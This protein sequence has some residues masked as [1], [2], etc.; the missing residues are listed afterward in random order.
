MLRGLPALFHRRHIG[1]RYY[2]VFPR[3]AIKIADKI[4]QPLPVVNRHGHSW[5]GCVQRCRW[6]SPMK[7][8]RLTAVNPYAFTDPL[9]AR[10]P[11]AGVAFARSVNNHWARDVP[12]GYV[13]AFRRPARWNNMDPALAEYYG[14]LRLIISGDLFQ[15][16]ADGGNF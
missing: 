9:L 11:D 15:S 1:P 2:S 7:L 3:M 12:R 10:L 4:H 14:K 16:A 5:D 6:L 13:H 8:G